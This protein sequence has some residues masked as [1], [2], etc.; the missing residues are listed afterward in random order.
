LT[1]TIEEKKNFLM[2]I[3]QVLLYF[4]CH[5]SLSYEFNILAGGEKETGHFE[6]FF[7]Q[8]KKRIRDTK[9]K[10]KTFSIFHNNQQHSSICSWSVCDSSGFETLLPTYT[11]ETNSSWNHLVSSQTTK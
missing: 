7:S 11:R 5:I 10:K 4:G 3:R 9:V 6:D 1:L 2:M 8:K